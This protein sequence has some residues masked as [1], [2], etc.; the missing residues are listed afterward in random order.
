MTT[1]DESWD[2]LKR[3]GWSVGETATA[4]TWLVIGANGENVIHA[5]GPTRA[6]VWAS[7]TEQAR[8]LGMLTVRPMRFDR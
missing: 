2:A 8:F 6:A 1:V 4:R 7:A 5:E 3:A